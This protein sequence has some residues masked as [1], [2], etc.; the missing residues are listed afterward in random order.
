[1]EKILR[2][3]KVIEV[4]GRSKPAIYAD[5]KKGLFPAPVKIGARAVGWTSSSVQ[6]WIAER[7]PVE[8]GSPA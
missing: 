4:T 6:H 3:P 8:L 5:I 1:M 7:A 2:L